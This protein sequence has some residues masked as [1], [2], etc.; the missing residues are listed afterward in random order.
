MKQHNQGEAQY[1]EKTSKNVNNFDSMEFSD[2][3][4]GS[5]SD[6][7]GMAP[8]Q[9]MLEQPGDAKLDADID[10]YVLTESSEIEQAPTQAELDLA[11]RNMDDLSGKANDRLQQQKAN[12]NTWMDMLDD[13]MKKADA[14][15]QQEEEEEPEWAEPVSVQNTGEPVQEEEK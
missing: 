15:V 14:P 1:F 13:D 12:D 11:Q 4:F 8:A 3:G 6:A 10:E 7:P 9:P 5:F 2:S